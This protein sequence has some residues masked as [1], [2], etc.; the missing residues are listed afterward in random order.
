[1]TPLAALLLLALPGEPAA[2]PPPGASAGAVGG[3]PAAASLSLEE[4]L[5][6]LDRQNLTLA[7]A[8]ARASAA[9]G[10]VREVEAPLLPSLGVTAGYTRNNDQAVVA[11]PPLAGFPTGSITI[12]PLDAW[13]V[14]GSLRVPLIVPEAWFALGASRDAAL[15]A[16]ASAEATLLTLRETLVRTGWV[17]WAGEEIV[18][19]SGR[20]LD[21]A[22]EQA[23]SARRQL[24]VGTGTSLSVLQAETAATRR[25]SDLVA[26]RSETARARLAVGVLLGRSD[27]VRIAMPP[28]N[29]PP[30]LDSAA[31]AEE[32]LDRRPEVRAQGALLSSREKEVRAADFSFAPE[33]SASASAFAQTAPYPTGEKSGW[34]A[35]LDLSW[36]LYDGG[37]R[38]GLSRKARAEAAEARAA[39]A[40]TRL[41][42]AQEV[43]NAARD[44]GVARE[45]LL[46]ATR[47]R[48]TAAEA[49]ASARRGFREGITSSLDVLS[50]NQ[51]LFEAEVQ[52]ADSSARLGGALAALDRAVGRSP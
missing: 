35:T 38:Y 20:A 8:R 51:V 22:R 44:V 37:Y 19:A 10:V 43:S 34:R 14:G 7:E 50:A 23:E 1:M 2:P 6:L 25:E 29:P 24:Q 5:R 32:A 3:M 33:I 12:Q 9:L 11:F 13:A 36:T 49:A 15:A 41:E 26:A 31:L 40:R 16:A 42:V 45:R 4:A 21:A 27:P 52:L 28:S 48:A 47:E 46:L 18:A 30:A 39:E 17:A